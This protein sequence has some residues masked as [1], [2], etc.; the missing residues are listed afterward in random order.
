M[1]AHVGCSRHATDQVGKDEIWM[2]HLRWFIERLEQQRSYVGQPNSRT[3]AP[4]E[5]PPLPQ[6]LQQHLS[7]LRY[8]APVHKCAK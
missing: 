6:H 4:R 3:C 7:L 5:A 8:L 2:K 1:S